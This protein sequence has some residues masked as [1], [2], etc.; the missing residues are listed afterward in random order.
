[1]IFTLYIWNIIFLDINSW[2]VFRAKNIL[3]VILTEFSIPYH[4]IDIISFLLNALN[5]KD[6]Q[7]ESI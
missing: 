1:M 5:K 3:W 7:C 4:V 2:A 6:L